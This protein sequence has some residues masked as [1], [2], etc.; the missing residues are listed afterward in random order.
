MSVFTTILECIHIYIHI[1]VDTAP[2]QVHGAT[3]LAVQL[4]KF[5]VAV[6]TRFDDN[7][8]ND[9]TFDPSRTI[10]NQWRICNID[11]PNATLVDRIQP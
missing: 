7:E 5:A 8:R 9:R 1:P 2:Y 6:T 11:V 4:V 10:Q 3:E